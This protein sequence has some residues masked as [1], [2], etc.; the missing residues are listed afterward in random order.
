MANVKVYT[1]PTCSSCKKTKE[2][3]NENN[4]KFE[5]VDVTKD[6][7]AVQEMLQKSG[8]MSVPVT[9]IDGQIILGFD[10]VKLKRLLNIGG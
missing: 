8:Q 9:D 6:Q 2:F 10:K 4:V 5:E 1:T 7:N 3:L